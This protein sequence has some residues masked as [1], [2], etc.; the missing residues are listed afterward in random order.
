MFKKS[1]S[2]PIRRPRIGFFAAVF[3]LF[4]SYILTLISTRKVSTQD[5][6]M[7][8]TNE[9]IHNL[10]NMV[11]FL[12]KSESAFRG[13]LITNDH[14]PLLKYESGKKMID[15]TFSVLQDLTKENVSQQKNLDTLQSLIQTKYSWIENYIKNPVSLEKLSIEN[16]NGNVEGIANAVAITNTI[17]K[18]KQEEINLRNSWSDKISKYS[19]LI[20]VLNII[21]IIIAVL[22]IIYSLLIYNKEKK[23]K[24]KAA[25]KAEKYKQELQ[26]RVNELAKLN[27]ELIELRRLEK[28]VVT[29]RIAR[30]MAHEVRNPLT[31]INLACEQLRAET[32]TEDSQIFFTMIKR[33]SE[34]INQLVSDLL[35]T[36]RAELSFSPASI[37]EI[38]DD[39]LYLALDRIQL[40]QINVEKHF[41]ADICS[42]PVD[43]EKLKIAFLNLIVNAIEAMDNNGKLEIT[44]K[45]LPGKCLVKISDNGKGMQKSQLDRLFEPYF[46]TKEK[47]NGLGLAN[48]H[49]IIIGHRGS[50]TAESEVG[51][52]T[53]FTI[54]FPLDNGQ[55]N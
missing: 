2:K 35:A 31:N 47:G 48:C 32:E 45:N 27:T 40:N 6:W 46:T 29:G 51:K 22:L 18:M 28:Y 19:G 10:D 54:T 34:R 49:N 30:V 14:E 4:L 44:T 39:S 36:T 38:L 23:D 20:Q 41:D 17:S 21:S 7:D 5:F 8:H 53:S 50:I 43:A 26:E 15:S 25:E 33:N 16:L 42:I 55:E 1:A 52:G 24:M 37:N 13:Y 12:E 11:G 9:V 3:L